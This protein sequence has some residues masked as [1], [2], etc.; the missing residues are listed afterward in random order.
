MVHV[1]LDEQGNSCFDVR[2][3]PLLKFVL[4]VIVLSKQRQLRG[5]PHDLVKA[6][7]NTGG[8]VARILFGDQV[9]PSRKSLEE[10]IHSAFRGNIFDF[11]LVD[12]QQHRVF[13]VQPAVVIDQTSG[14]ASIVRL[15]RTPDGRACE[16]LV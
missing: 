4:A 10:Y 2:F 5:L 9:S 16:G 14:R 12:G 15:H 11:S 8:P 3:P 13:L 6:R 1:G 7:L